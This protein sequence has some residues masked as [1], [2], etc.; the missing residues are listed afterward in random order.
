FDFSD[1]EIS[2]RTSIYCGADEFA[3]PTY[4]QI[5]FA[6]VIGLIM[7]EKYGN[8]L[9]KVMFGVLEPDDAI[10]SVESDD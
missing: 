8:A 10:E 6:L 9:V 1:G 7:I 3:P 2:Y 4:E 5:D